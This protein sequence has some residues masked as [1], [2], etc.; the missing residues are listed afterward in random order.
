MFLSFVNSKRLLKISFVYSLQCAP[1]Y[2]LTFS[3]PMKNQVCILFLLLF[4][5][6][7]GKL[8]LLTELGRQNKPLLVDNGHI[9]NN[10]GIT[11]L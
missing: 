11:E 8:C 10:M 1:F 7:P 5:T 3:G 9:G 6:G 2:R 4:E